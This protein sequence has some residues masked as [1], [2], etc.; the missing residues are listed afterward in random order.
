MRLVHSNDIGDVANDDNNKPSTSVTDPQ[1]CD[2]AVFRVTTAN[3]TSDP[4]LQRCP[5][6]SN[7]IFDPYSEGGKTGVC[8]RA[9][10]QQPH[11]GVQVSELTEKS[12]K[13]PLVTPATSTELR[14]S[15]VNKRVDT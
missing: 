13:D 2:I 6:G 12:R 4:A 1:R 8:C 11:G 9:V 10:Q 3:E 15:D 7:C 14:L 5:T